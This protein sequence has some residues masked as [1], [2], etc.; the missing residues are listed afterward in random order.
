MTVLDINFG[1]VP[2]EYEMIEVGVYD[3]EIDGVPEVKVASSG[4]GNVI[5]TKWKITSEGDFFGKTIMGFLCTWTD[6]GK[7]DIKKMLKSLG[8]DVDG[9]VDLSECE[10][11]V[12]RIV[13][14]A[15]TMTDK[16]TGDTKET[17]QIKEYL[18]S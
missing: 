13:V 1:D 16:L 9:Q 4:N 6:M 14:S 17:R 18:V 3:A 11:K 5:H 10:G 2:D 7:V 12:G 15:G 8:M